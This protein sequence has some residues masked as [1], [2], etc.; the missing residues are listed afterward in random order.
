MNYTIDDKVIVN[1]GM[2]VGLIGTVTGFGYFV[3]KVECVVIETED[4]DIFRFL[5]ESLQLAE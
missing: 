1:R 5:P 3:S 4:G 2:F